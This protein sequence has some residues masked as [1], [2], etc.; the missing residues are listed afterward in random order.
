M[1]PHDKQS[2]SKKQCCDFMQDSIS[3]R[4]RDFSSVVDHILLSGI[5]R[6]PDVT[7]QMMSILVLQAKNSAVDIFTTVRGITA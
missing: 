5:V 4:L 2:S 6:N 3:I 7:V 1:Q